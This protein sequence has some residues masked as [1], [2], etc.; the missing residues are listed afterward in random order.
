MVCCESPSDGGRRSRGSER[1]VLAVRPTR[2]RPAASSH[3][4]AAG[5]RTMAELATSMTARV[6]SEPPNGVLGSC[7]RRNR[8][9]SDSTQG[10]GTVQTTT[11]S[12]ARAHHL[13]REAHDLL[14]DLPV[15]DSVAH[16]ND[17]ASKV[18]RERGRL[19]QPALALVLARLEGAHLAVD[20]VQ[21]SS[22]DLDG[23]LGRLE[24]LRSGADEQGSA[25]A[26]GGRGRCSGRR[27][28]GPARST[29][30]SACGKGSLVKT[31]DRT[32]A[33]IVV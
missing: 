17:R 32:G 12:D 27:T 4:R 3:P 25:T 29:S 24:A 2:G 23:D 19:G 13:E 14:T 20:G 16:R 21:R 9:V 28:V 7:E 11:E 31:Q 18:A 15:L 30:S 6:L 5:L 8:R 22:D 10:G 26:C 33:C 1:V